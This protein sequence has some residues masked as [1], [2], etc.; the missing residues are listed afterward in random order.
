[1]RILRIDGGSED[2]QWPDI[3]DLHFNSY[4]ISEFKPLAQLSSLKKRKDETIQLEV[5]EKCNNLLWLREGPATTEIKKTSRVTLGDNYMLAVFGVDVYSAERLIEK[6]RGDTES[7][8]GIEQCKLM[9][10]LFIQQSQN[11]EVA[12]E[13]IKVPLQCVFDMSLIETPARGNLCEHIQCFSLEH[14]IIFMAQMT[15]RRWRCPICKNL[16]LGFHIDSY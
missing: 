13:S 15:P 3:G 16:I 9:I 6:V 8:M 7:Y 4:R 12:I 11:D 14:F 2:V 10:K 1:M 5:T